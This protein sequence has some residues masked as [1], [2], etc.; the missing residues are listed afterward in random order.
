MSWHG[1]S[2]AAL[3]R[4]LALPRVEALRSVESTMDAAHALAAEGAPAGTLVIAEE[5]TAGRGRGGRAWTSRAGAGL[6]LTLIERPR[7]DD[8]LDVLSL[9]VGLQLAPVLERWSPGPVQLKWPN[10]LYIARRKL[11]GVLIEARWRGGLVDWVAIGLGIN[12]RPPADVPEAIGLPGA[13]AEQVLAEVIPAARAAAFAG[14]PLRPDEL[15]A[16]AARDL[17]RGHRVLAP[18][19]GTV[20]GIS[21]SGELLLETPGGVTPFRAGSLVFAT[22]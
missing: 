12:L 22:T 3:A 18:A 15:A 6:W 17:A 9:R 21:A 10:D 20:R 1:H 4:V 5:Q 8:G 14:G 19:D 2:G 13:D 11:A 16:F 7:R